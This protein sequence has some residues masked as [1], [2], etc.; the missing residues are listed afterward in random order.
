MLRQVKKSIVTFV[1][2]LVGIFVGVFVRVIVGTL[3]GALVEDFACP[4]MPLTTFAGSI[5]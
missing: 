1:G 4:H 2:N 5:L 3:V